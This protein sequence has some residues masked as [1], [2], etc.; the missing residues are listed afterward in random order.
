MVFDGEP[1]T[2]M[3]SAESCTRE[4]AVVMRSAACLSVCNPLTFSPIPHLDID[5]SFWYAYTSGILFKPVG[6]YIYIKVIGSRSR[7]QEK[8]RVCLPQA[9]A[10]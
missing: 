5:S 8:K 3:P 9:F 7:S 10:V 2:G 4:C 6:I 1:L